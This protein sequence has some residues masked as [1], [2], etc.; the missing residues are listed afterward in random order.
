[1]PRMPALVVFAAL[2]ALMAA[3]SSQEEVTDHILGSLSRSADFLE[4]EH[5]SINL[6]GVVGY[7]ILQGE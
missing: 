3:S 5:A 2:V 4:R 1:M 6:D 7:L